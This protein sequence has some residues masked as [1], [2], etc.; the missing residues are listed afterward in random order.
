MSPEANYTMLPPVMEGLAVY[1]HHGTSE[2]K[3]MPGT[4]PTIQHGVW[5]TVVAYEMFEW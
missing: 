3:G 1:I 2:M 5:H 4:H